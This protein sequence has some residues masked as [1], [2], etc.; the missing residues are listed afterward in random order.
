MKVSGQ[1]EACQH[2]W[3]PALEAG[4]ES[5]SLSV[6]GAAGVFEG[7]LHLGSCK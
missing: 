5:T 6:W 3:V 4:S 1:T 2:C 7:K